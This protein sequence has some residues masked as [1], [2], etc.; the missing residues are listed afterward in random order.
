VLENWET[1][2]KNLEPENNR[3]ESKQG[4]IIV[5]PLL[6]TGRDASELLKTIQRSLDPIPLSVGKAIQARPPARLVFSVGE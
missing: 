2:D 6:V 3:G 1:D 4:E 5:R